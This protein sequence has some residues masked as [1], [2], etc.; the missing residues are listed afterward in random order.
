MRTEDYPSIKIELENDRQQVIFSSQS[1]A[2]NHVPWKVTVAQANKTTEYTS[3]SELP[4]QAL[5]ILNP[6]IDRAGIDQ[7]IHRRRQGNK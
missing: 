2:S 5:Q 4:T 6:W 1:Q 7:I 3:D